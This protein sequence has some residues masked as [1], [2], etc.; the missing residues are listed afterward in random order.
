MTDGQEAASG[1]G[2]VTTRPW[3]VV[4]RSVLRAVGSVIVFVAVYYVL[5]LDTSATWAAITILVSGLVVLMALVAYSVRSILR[6]PFPG[7]RAI[8]ALAVIVPL[9]LL[10]FASAYVVMER[11]ARTSFTQPLTHTDALYF[12]V[13]VFTTVG[14]GDIT[15]RTEAARVLVTI[16]MIMDLVIIGV[17]IQAIVGAARHGRERRSAGSSL[18]NNGELPG[19]ATR[20]A[21]SPDS[22]FLS[23]S[24]REGGLQLALP[25]VELVVES[26]GRVD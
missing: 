7:L 19:R 16:Q 6:S 14:F 13:T 12:T 11:L 10:L 23:G 21:A 5:P 20:R 3:A 1:A 18:F 15:A 25:L 24:G 4:I 26:D 9:F 22:Y 17:A 8:E 2:R